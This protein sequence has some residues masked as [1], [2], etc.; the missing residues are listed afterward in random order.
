MQATLYIRLGSEPQGEV[1]WTSNSVQATSAVREGEL[2][3]A[4]L[5]TQGE[6]LCVL[7][8]AAPLLP[9]FATL[10]PLQGQKLRRAVPYAVEE[11]LADDVEAYHF[12][13]GKRQA[14][15]TLPLVAVNREQMVAWQTRFAEADIKPHTALN[16]AQLL[17]WQPGEMSL[18][19]ESDGALLR[20][21]NY[22]A[23]SLPLDGLEPLLE[24]ALQRAP[25]DVTSLHTYDARGESAEEPRWQGALGELEQQYEVVTEPL[26]LLISGHDQSAINLLQGEFGRKEQLGR[27]WRPWRATAA[28]LA[29]W[30]LLLGGESIYNYQRLA[31][32]EER[33]YRAVE[34]VY[35]DTFPEA[36]NVAN[37]RVQMERKLTELQ[38]GGNGGAFVALLGAS[39]PVLNSAKGV[40]LQN[41]RYREG[42]LELALE[43][44]DLPTLDTLKESLQQQGLEVEIRNA[45][46]R[47]NKV[48]GRVV[49]R[50]MG[51]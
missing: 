40:Q 8:P 48:E 49:I 14:D 20:I 13:L 46:S 31:A 44:K 6:R 41:L 36:K 12:A 9:L 15:G 1:R 47:D 38:G 7:L 3:E 27:L 42:E 28:L 21:S 51:Q 24:L 39:G 33:L 16:E 18:L 2:K 32:E 50:E 5:R 37:P 17:P 34:Q 10:P 29:C 45:T 35:R 25:D 4:P 11:Q 23:Y 30:L 22:E 26:S 19:L 43:L